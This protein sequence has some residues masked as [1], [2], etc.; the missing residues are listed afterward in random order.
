M[1]KGTESKA[2]ILRQ[3]AEELLKNKAASASLSDLKTSASPGDLKTS[4][5][6]S[7]TPSSSLPSNFTEAKLVALLHEIEVNQIEL[8]MQK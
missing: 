6:P 7:V 2:A 1:N 5:T 3:L 8:E 4:A